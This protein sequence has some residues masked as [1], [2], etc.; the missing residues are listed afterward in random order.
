[1]NWAELKQR[2]PLDPKTPAEYTEALRRLVQFFMDNWDN[3]EDGDGVNRSPDDTNQTKTDV[4]MVI[5]GCADNACQSIKQFHK[6]TAEVES[7]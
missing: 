4:F 5:A 6:L 7:K 1:M 2:E 3:F